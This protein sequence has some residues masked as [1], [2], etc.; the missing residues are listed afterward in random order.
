LRD[1]ERN[2]KIN[3]RIEKMSLKNFLNIFLTAKIIEICSQEIF[4]KKTNP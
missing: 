4:V 2:R 3:R 1:F